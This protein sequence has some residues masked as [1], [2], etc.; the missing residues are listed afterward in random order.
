MWGR[1]QPSFIF[2]VN[3]V[4]PGSELSVL[5]AYMSVLTL[6][7]HCFAVTTLALGK[8]LNW[9]VWVLVLYSFSKLFWLSWVPCNSIRISGSAFPSVEEP[10]EILKGFA[11]SLQNALE[12][13]ALL[14]ILVFQSTNTRMYFHLFKSS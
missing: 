12:N 2:H 6:V 8:F 5:L 4:V 10:I 11:F 13:I 7:S 3:I 1:S 9:K 14:T